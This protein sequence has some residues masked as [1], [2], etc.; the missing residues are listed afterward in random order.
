MEANQTLNENEENQN[1]TDAQ[2]LEELKDFLNTICGPMCS[3]AIESKPKDIPNYMINYLQNKFGYSSSGLQYEEKK[4][5]EKLRNE[6]EIFRDMDEHT[7]YAEL[8]K[9]VKKEIK[10]NEKKSK[11]PP[12]PK[13][14]LPPDEVIISDDEDYNDPDEIDQNLDNVEFIQK[15]NLNNKRIAVTENSLPDEDDG[16]IKTYKKSNEL[17]EFMRINLMKSPIF[18]E[19]SLDVLKQCIDAMEEKDI[20]A[21]TDVVKQGEIG[22]TFFFIEEGELECKIQFTKITKEGNRKKVE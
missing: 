1:N 11:I 20:P 6:V 5:L 22:D 21:V 8:Q 7:Y 19:L 12:K 17:I 4:E 13:P 10:V 2:K 9:Q 16:P 15:C 14:R 18:S 3:D